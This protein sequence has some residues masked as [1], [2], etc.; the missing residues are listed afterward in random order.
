MLIIWSWK[1]IDRSVVPT[2]PKSISG[3]GHNIVWK[4][5][6]MRFQKKEIP[7][8]W[9]FAI[10]LILFNWN[11][12]ESEIRRV[13]WLWCLS[14]S[15]DRRYV[16]SLPRKWPITA[17]NSMLKYPV[18][19]H[20]MQCHHVFFQFFTEFCLIWW[21]H[22]TSIRV[23]T[24]KCLF[25]FNVYLRPFLFLSIK[26]MWH[27]QLLI[28]IWWNKIKFFIFCKQ[29]QEEKCIQLKLLHYNQIFTLRTTCLFHSKTFFKKNKKQKENISSFTKSKR[30]ICKK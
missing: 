17:E 28:F 27:M 10:Y 7:R 25:T 26:E 21:Q 24:N 6:L 4:P 20:Q 13:K 22:S 23:N 18:S 5:I 15:D 29:N 1:W 3:L 19:A 16:W 2:F 8:A 30:K 9:S 11:N 14:P 12:I